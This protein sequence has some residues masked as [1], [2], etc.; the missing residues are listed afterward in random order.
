MLAGSMQHRDHKGNSGNLVAGSVQ[1]M[2]AGKGII[3]SEMPMQKDGLMWGFQLWVNL[4]AAEKM[5]EPRYQE[6]RPE[7]IPEVVREDGVRVRVIAGESGGMRGA[8]GGIATD[9]VYLDVDLPARSRFEQTV[10]PDHTFFTYVVAGEGEFGGGDNASGTKVLSGHLAVF[11]EGE[12]V[13][14]AT[15]E[16]AVRFLLLG[17]R[18]LGEPVERYGPFVMTT[19]D[20]IT[21]AVRD[22]QEGRFID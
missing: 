20:Q 10:D 13:A 3:H 18:P 6:I 19:R 21:Q 22:F 9:P 1:W 12:Q 7:D 11:S 16:A 2:T 4:P 14:V 17:A 5:C 8:I 15:S